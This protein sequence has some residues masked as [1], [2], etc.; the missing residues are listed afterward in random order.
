M[1]S[2]SAAVFDG[3]QLIAGRCEPMNTGH[4]EK[5]V[6]MIEQIMA[7][8]GLTYPDLES[9]VVTTGPGTFTGQRIGLSVARGLALVSGVPTIGVTGFEAI[10][11]AFFAA[12]PDH[13]GPVLPVY[14][15]RRNEAYDQ[16]MQK[17]DDGP[18]PH[19]LARHRIASL[20]QIVEDLPTGPVTLVGSGA[21]LIA[22]RARRDDLTIVTGYDAPD[23]TRFGHIAAHVTA[24]PDRLARPLYLRAPDA[25]LPQ[26]L[27]RA[28]GDL[29]ELA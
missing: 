7:E 3:P 11:A 18:L 14:D 1:P 10:G 12:H 24:G 19:M 16:L 23:A 26:N 22:E 29:P 5:L 17:S 21:E 2:C 25:K 13:Q 9:I 28:R 6:P 20:E 27:P 15:A 8:A 4:A